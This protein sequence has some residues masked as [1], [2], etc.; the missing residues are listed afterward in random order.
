MPSKKS[1]SFGNDQKPSI[2]YKDLA[3]VEH[4]IPP[5]ESKPSQQPMKTAS[6]Q[7]TN[8]QIEKR[9]FEIWNERGQPPGL[10]IDHWLQAERE[11]MGSK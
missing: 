7:V 2:E 1:Y 6:I 3:K 4:K 8:K 5:G 10:D 9:A 11:L